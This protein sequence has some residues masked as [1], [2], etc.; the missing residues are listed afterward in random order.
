MNIKPF[1]PDELLTRLPPDLVNLH[2]T[3]ITPDGVATFS[4]DNAA[5]LE[6]WWLV[7]VAKLRRAGEGYWCVLNKREFTS[8]KDVATGLPVKRVS[9]CLFE[10][11]TA[12]PQSAE[13]TRYAFNTDADTGKTLPR[14]T[15]VVFV[16][17]L[18]L[19]KS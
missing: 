14:L 18:P 3:F 1:P 8:I 13:T 11:N 10:G 16:D 2:L 4:S 15:D 7:Q 12:T 5:A 17:F 9:S 6:H 19:A